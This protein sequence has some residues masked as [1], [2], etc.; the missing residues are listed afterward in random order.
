MHIIDFLARVPDVIWSGLIASV[1]TLSGV[2]ISNRSNTK[3]LIR[4]L[5]HD[6][7]EKHKER[8]ASMRRDVYLKAAEELAKVSSFF[9]RLPQIDPTELVSYLSDT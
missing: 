4:Q 9:G 5:A 8:F 3:R 2:M 6:S 7:Q 1:V